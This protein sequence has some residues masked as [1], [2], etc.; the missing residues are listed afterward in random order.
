[1][2]IP[3]NPDYNGESQLG[4]NYVAARDPEGPPRERRARLPASGDEA[5]QPRSAH[6]GARDAR[7]FEGKRA[8]G[9][10]YRKGGRN[11]PLM[12]VRARREVILA[13]AHSI[14][15]SSCSSP[16]SASPRSCR[17]KGIEVHHALPG[18]GENLRDH[19][20][21]RFSCA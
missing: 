9:V 21:P 1:M 12:E 5:A 2:G 18:V 16:A 14:R 11:G 17:S 8:V 13:A 15:R 19:Y 4:I 3:R 20:A 7:S 6:Q 10:R